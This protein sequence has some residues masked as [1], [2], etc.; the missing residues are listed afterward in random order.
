MHIYDKQCGI[1][2]KN[3]WRGPNFQ[4]SVFTMGRQELCNENAKKTPKLEK[5]K[6]NS[7][8]LKGMTHIGWYH[9]KSDVLRIPKML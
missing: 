1:M 9:E 6:R 3:Q 8:F 2:Q 7:N 5:L 4:Y